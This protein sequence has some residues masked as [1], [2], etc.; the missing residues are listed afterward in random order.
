MYGPLFLAAVRG[1][2]PLPVRGE[3]RPEIHAWDTNPPD[4]WLVTDWGKGRGL[5][6]FQDV[7]GVPTYFSEGDM[8]DKANARLQVVV[9]AATPALRYQYT[10]RLMK[11]LARHPQFEILTSSES[12]HETT[13]K[14]YGARFDVSCW[15]IAD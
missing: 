1:E 3:D 7:G 8:A 5:I 2:F 6:I 15:Y 14:L 4:D 10:R 9:W 11:A 12:I 13:V